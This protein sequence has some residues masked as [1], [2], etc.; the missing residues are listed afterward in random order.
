MR[1]LIAKLGS[2][3]LPLLLLVSVATLVTAIRSNAEI[4]NQ[5][6]LLR[7]QHQQ[8]GE[9]YVTITIK[10]PD[11]TV[12]GTYTNVSDYVEHDTHVTF[13]GQGS[14]ET[15]PVSHTVYVGPGWEI[16]KQQQA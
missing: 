12:H 16:I 3:I 1:A 7:E 13:T 15:S 5:F 9:S 11:G 8:Q 6:A 10:K 14:G 2:W 4:E